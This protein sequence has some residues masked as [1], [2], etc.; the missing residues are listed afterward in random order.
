MEKVY[1]IHKGFHISHILPK[2]H[3]NKSFIKFSF[4]FS[5]ECLYDLGN[6]NNQDINK[7]FG[8]GFGFNHHIQSFRIGW[9]C[10]KQ[11]DKIQLFS[12][13]YNDSIRKMEY[14]CDINVDEVYDCYIYFD[15]ASN[16]IF[17]DISQESFN[18]NNSYDFRFKDCKRWGFYLFPYFGGDE[19]SPH[20]MKSTVKY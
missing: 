4:K 12:Y 19:C 20:K 9:N 17:V 8:L 18:I 11:N 5:K 13:Y 1:T 3:N 14:I 7:L 2:F 16:R 15:R 6:D 10:E